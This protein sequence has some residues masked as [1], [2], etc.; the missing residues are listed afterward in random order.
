MTTT[1]TPG[2]Q[3][4]EAIMGS[5]LLPFTGAHRGLLLEGIAINDFG[6]NA[7]ATQTEL[8]PSTVANHIAYMHILIGTRSVGQILHKTFEAL[9]QEGIDAAS[10]NSGL[11]ELSPLTVPKE[12][13][14]LPEGPLSALEAVIASGSVVDAHD[15][16][17]R[18]VATVR[19]QVST[20]YQR[21]EE[22]GLSSSRTAPAAYLTL[23]KLDI[24]P[25]VKH[26]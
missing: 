12:Q 16:L 24:L 10:V 11:R 19:N 3:L 15:V 26:V 7:L 22:L 21:L 25:R 13:L 1:I 2:A 6:R 4:T 9:G 20:M 17:F 8:A 23:R 5:E 18:S 14:T